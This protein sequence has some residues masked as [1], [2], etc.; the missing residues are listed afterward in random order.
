MPSRL[1][2]SNPAGGRRVAITGASRGIGL[3]IAELLAASGAQVIAGSRSP[4]EQKIVGVRFLPLD[5]T[6][7]ESVREFARIAIESDV[8]TLVNNAGVGI[9]SPLNDISVDDYRRVMDTNVLGLILTSKYFAS[10]FRKRHGC[11]GSSQVITI[12]SDV[13]DRTFAGGGLYCASKYA[14]RALTR[15]L[16]FEG[17]EYGLRVTEI[18]PGMTDTHFNGNVPGSARRAQDL[19]ASDVADAVLYALLSPRHVRLDELVI[20]PASQPVVF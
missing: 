12:T 15:T 16:A 2:S 20:H 13:S 7:E 18:R 9:F 10:H 4:P 1:S 3:A 5:I 17:E 11:G 8:D 19:S 6:E 14:Q